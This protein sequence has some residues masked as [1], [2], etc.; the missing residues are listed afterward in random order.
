MEGSPS[1]LVRVIM[2]S[3]EEGADQ[4]VMHKM[5]EDGKKRRD[6]NM[7]RLNPGLL[8]KQAG[9]A[10]FPPISGPTCTSGINTSQQQEEKLKRA[11]VVPKPEDKAL[12]SMDIEKISSFLSD[13]V[14][15]ASMKSTSELAIQKKKVFEDAVW[16]DRKHKILEGL[17]AGALGSGI[18]VG[19]S[20]G[21][22]HGK[23]VGLIAAAVGAL[24]G[25]GIGAGFG[26]LNSLKSRGQM[27]ALYR[28]KGE[29]ELNN[30]SA[31]RNPA[32]SGLL[33][34]SLS[35][36]LGAGAR[37]AITERIP[38]PFPHQAG[39]AGELGKRIQS[40]G[41]GLAM[42]GVGLGSTYFSRNISDT[43]HEKSAD[44]Y[45]DYPYG[46]VSPEVPADRYSTARQGLLYGVSTLHPIMASLAAAATAHPDE[47]YDQL[48]RTLVGGIA[49][50]TVG[51]LAGAAFGGPAGYGVGSILGRPLGTY[52]AHH[53][54]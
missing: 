21:I 33:S 47:R 36:A 54:D 16:A 7:A 1:T 50:D 4:V 52:I 11:P 27:E 24:L 44:T 9:G 40:M 15:R 19:V 45:M 41:P 6:E 32:T 8:A 3:I 26:A 39:L 51:G 5:R 34:G 53:M 14:G 35:G 22:E 23:K 25:G 13:I 30:F 28:E 49:G 20:L 18:G 42:T 43:L 12:S 46:E 38:N 48:G 31:R 10:N 37:L 29:E 17:S 2:E